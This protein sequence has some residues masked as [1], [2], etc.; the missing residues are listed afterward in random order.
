MLFDDFEVTGR[1]FLSNRNRRR[2]QPVLR[3]TTRKSRSKR[4]D[5]KHLRTGALITAGLI[6]AGA[7]LWYG[8]EFAWR[9]F[10]SEN[11][12]FGIKHVEING[13]GQIVK[14]YITGKQ[15]IIEGRNLFSVDISEV[16]ETFLDRAPNYRTMEI[17]RVLPD[18]LKVEVIERIPVARIGWQGYLAVDDEGAVFSPLE[19]SASLPLIAGYESEDLQPGG[20]V[21]GMAR[22]AIEA[23]E[24]CRT[25]DVDLPVS[26]VDVRG[27]HNII[28]ILAN[29]K[30]GI[31]RWKGM[32]EMGPASEERL[33]T[34]LLQWKR[35]LEKPEG[36]GCSTFDLTFSNR[37][38]ARRG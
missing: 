22:A 6:V 5:I 23:I 15:K 31:L 24:V 11:P 12:G 37:I 17:T 21:N 26:A 29:G 16:R 30:R 9:G 35:T 8:F 18:K 27:E 14:D 25:S 38:I 13:G 3:V 20:R 36:R 4:M 28:V 33:R 1:K 34:K 7:G 32:G 2:K 19:K 10:F